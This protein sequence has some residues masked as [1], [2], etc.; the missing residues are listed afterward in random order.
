[1]LAL[2]GVS[3]CSSSNSTGPSGNVVHE[4]G[5]GNATGSMTAT[6]SGRSFEAQCLV[7]ITYNGKIFDLAGTDVSQSNATNFQIVGFAVTASGPGTYT[8]D[9]TMGGGASGNNASYSIG[10]NQSWVSGAGFGGGG[11]VTLDKLTTHERQVQHHVLTKALEPSSPQGVAHAPAQ[12]VSGGRAVG[13]VDGV[14]HV[15]VRIQWQWEWQRQW[16]RQWQRVRLHAGVA[17]DVDCV[18]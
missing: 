4:C 3:G 12:G 17:R 14:W 11:T 16:E 5:G 9:S 7:T 8:I 2:V 6:I 18:C 15:A 10:G 1:M 13:A